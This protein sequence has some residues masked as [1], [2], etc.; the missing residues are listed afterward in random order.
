MTIIPIGSL[1]FV[2]LS[3]HQRT[4]DVIDLYNWKSLF[5]YNVIET[6]VMKRKCGVK[7]SIKGSHVTGNSNK[8][9]H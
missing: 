9:L 3:Y 5:L 6:D 8:V 1:S 4:E 7:G 2:S